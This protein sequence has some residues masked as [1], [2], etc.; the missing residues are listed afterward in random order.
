MKI[1]VAYDGSECA[2][3]AIADLRNAGLPK[4]SEVLIAT[5]AHEGWPHSKH[6]AAELG[7]FG[8]PWKAM[9]AEAEACAAKA[10]ERLQSEFP[11][12]RISSESLWG[13]PS[14]IIQKTIDHWMP[15]LLVVGSHGRTAAGR[16][17]LGSV[18]LNLVH[19][20]HCPVRIV[21][22]GTPGAKT[23]LRIV[24]ASDGSP[25]SDAVV[26]AVQRRTWP[27]G[28]RARVVSIA[29]TLVPPVPQLVP[30]IEGRTFAT[31]QAFEVIAAADERERSRLRI[32]ADAAA[33]NLER[34]GLE[35]DAVVVDGDPLTAIVAEAERWQA[36]TIFL[37]ARG[38]GAVDRFL[39]GSVSTAVV[40]HAHCSVEVV[41]A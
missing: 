9:M 15:D 7:A 30:A 37:G 6:P 11:G 31:E 21:R 14:N 33:I 27:E 29:Q 17:L 13:D 12:W 34:A 8:N 18:S 25:Q 39:L 5:V 4:Q 41:R 24:V 1:L 2:D 40:T 36:D 23:P 22:A 32:A 3:A 35:V 10:R 26:Q 38:L 16:L 28:T 19:H 20:A